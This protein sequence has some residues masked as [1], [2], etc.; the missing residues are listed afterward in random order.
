MTV[1]QVG[2]FVIL[3]KL[4]EGP[5]CL[6]FGGEK[7][8]SAAAFVLKRVKPGLASLPRIAERI[9]AQAISP[10]R[11]EHPLLAGLITILL[12][13]EDYWLV[14]EAAAGEPLD[15]HL[16]KGSVRAPAAV[17]APFGELL[18]AFA[19][20]HRRGFVHGNLRTSNFWVDPAGR[21]RVT[22]FE[23]L[24]IFGAAGPAR[25]LLSTPEYRSPEH[26]N[27]E[28][29]DARSDVYSLGIVLQHLLTGKASGR[30]VKGLPPQVAGLIEKA[31][32]TDKASRFRNAAEFRMAVE[33]CLTSLPAMKAAPV[34]P[35]ALEVPT[36]EPP[37]PPVSMMEPVPDG[38]NN[39]LRWAGAGLAA[40]L[41]LGFVI[42]RTSAP[43]KTAAA[44]STPAAPV[45]A[46]SPVTTT[47]P[48]TKAAVTNPQTAAVKTETKQAVPTP[49]QAAVPTPA[50]TPVQTQQASAPEPKKEPP[51]Q[52]VWAQ[53]QTPVRPAGAPAL[54]SDV[55]AVSNG[56]A[57]APP[58]V[59][60]TDV[61]VL[62]PPPEAKTP[63][64]EPAV[65]RTGRVV[66]AKLVRGGSPT[67]PQ[68]ARQMKVSGVVKLEIQVAAD[69]RVVTAKAIS[70]H[71]V[72][73]AAAM[74]A[75]RKWTYTAA[76]MDG[77]AIPSI[78]QVDISFTSR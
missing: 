10:P 7:Q 14:R 4:G 64:A 73:A 52:F 9:R 24:R 50:Q 57:P 54:P 23:I 61:Q 76:T 18:E 47:A 60:G 40:A 45:V 12:E 66:A 58:P 67:Y 75:A 42:W 28:E 63:A 56:A 27:G 37:P 21:Y 65:R 44:K 55:P 29:L 26:T 46:P 34:I 71:P 62:A 30:A 1:T 72:L 33:E 6:T 70:G 5:F 32:A 68:L 35:A 16:R 20:A 13:G 48:A 3:P 69:G 77:Q 11:V 38:A 43:E 78:T 19:A 41:A 22:D 15:A 74:E 51:K 17:L 25:E 59:V 49:V 8:G 39:K 36:A 53:A 31:T 2:E